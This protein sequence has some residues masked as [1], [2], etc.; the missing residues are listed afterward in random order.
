MAFIVLSLIFNLY[1][2]DST[3]NLEYLNKIKNSYYTLD[4]TGLINFT[5][6]VTSLK[7]DKFRSENWKDQQVYPLQ[8]IWFKPDKIYLSQMGV[9]TLSTEKY[10][11][12]QLLVDGLK[13]QIKGV[14]LDL[15]RFYMT[16]VVKSFGKDYK[17]RN[18]E[19]AIQVTL[20][21][22]TSENSSNVKFLFGLNGLC[23]YNEISYLQENKTITIYPDFI[24]KDD[25]WLCKGW[26]VQTIIGGEIESGFKLE[27]IHN[28]IK[29][30]W[31]PA[32]IQINVQKAEDPGAT[33]FDQIQIKNYMFDQSI[34]LKDDL[35]K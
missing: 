27:I 10:S 23:L 22:G 5:A 35:N 30:I 14:L 19:E 33:Y 31:L 6:S 4:Q 18:N 29:N 9:P 13:Q 15:V 26:T 12:Y 34:Q 7:F 25:K 11:E 8:L 20:K 17:L 21:G 3:Q 16:G 24:T 28:Y 2:Q 1:G 32:E